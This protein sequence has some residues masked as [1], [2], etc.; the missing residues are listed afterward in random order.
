M[1][2][3]SLTAIALFAFGLGMTSFHSEADARRGRNV[4]IGVAA[5]LAT[6]AIISEAARAD[7][8]RRRG[9]RRYSCERLM[10]KCDAGEDWACEKYERRC[11]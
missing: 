5:G 3:L 8:R 9:D 2:L 11:D 7:E 10:D 4:A 6:M 1:R